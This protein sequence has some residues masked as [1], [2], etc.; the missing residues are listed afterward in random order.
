MKGQ[1]T[2]NRIDRSVECIGFFDALL[3]S[4]PRIITLHLKNVIESLMGVEKFLKNDSV[5]CRILD[6]VSSIVSGKTKVCINYF[7]TV[8]F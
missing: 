1:C 8:K 5:T 6:V 2:R 3:D 4:Y 7:S